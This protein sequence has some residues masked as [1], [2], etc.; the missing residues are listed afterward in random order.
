M[1]GKILA[2]A[3][4]PG[5]A[6]LATAGYFGAKKHLYEPY[7]EG[8]ALKEKGALMKANMKEQIP[9]YLLAGLGSA[10]LG[11]MGGYALGKYTSGTSKYRSDY[12]TT[13]KGGVRKFRE[14]MTGDTGLEGAPNYVD[15]QRDKVKYIGALSNSKGFVPVGSRNVSLNCSDVLQAEISGEPIRGRDVLSSLGEIDK[16]IAFSQ[17]L[18]GL[19]DKSASIMM[20]DT[21]YFDKE[22]LGALGTAALSLAGGSALG[23]GVYSELERYKKNNIQ[24]KLD[25]GRAQL[26]KGSFWRDNGMQIATAAGVLLGGTAGYLGGSESGKAQK[27]ELFNRTLDQKAYRDAMNSYRRTY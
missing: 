19:I 26:E 12:P 2:A 3:L 1:N 11:G 20:A 10:A 15:A 5:T 21:G 23:L 24:P 7:K 17:V 27:D 4:I 18:N 16:D 14:T 8:E 25:E 6:A 22:A 13:F 9:K